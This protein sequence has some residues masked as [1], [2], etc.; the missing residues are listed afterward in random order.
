MSAL[1]ADDIAVL[2]AL[3][4]SKFVLLLRSGATVTAA[5]RF[6]AQR[7]EAP[8]VGAGPPGAL[9]ACAVRVLLQPIQARKRLAA[10]RVAAP[11]CGTAHG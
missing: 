8:A 11:A 9:V 1:D 2:H 6:A 7:G 4:G 3:R 5:A 10:A